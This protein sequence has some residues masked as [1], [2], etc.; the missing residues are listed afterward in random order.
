MAT[1]I[2]TEYYGA[3]SA[4]INESGTYITGNAK[5]S[6]YDIWDLVDNDI[7]TGGA[8]DYTAAPWGIGECSLSSDFSG[9]IMK[10]SANQIVTN[11]HF[12]KKGNSPLFLYSNSAAIPSMDFTGSDNTYGNC[13]RSL[14]T[15]RLDPATD[16]QDDTKIISTLPVDTGDNYNCIIGGALDTKPITYLNYNKVRILPRYV[17]IV[18]TGQQAPT[19]YYTEW[20]LTNPD[21][22]LDDGQI[23]QIVGFDI[24]CFMQNGTV[25]QMV[26]NGQYSKFAPSVQ[27]NP[28]AIPDILKSSYYDNYDNYDNWIRTHRTIMSVGT[29]SITTRYNSGNYGF[30]RPAYG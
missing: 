17:W 6:P 16:I 12:N 4:F 24:E 22:S 18:R 8:F 28:L 26:T 23:Y 10:N 5:T 25:G 11:Y 21:S 27:S 3:E 29:W 15:C 19:K 14:T 1:K 9:K 13:L 20:L 7:Y 2:N 30:I